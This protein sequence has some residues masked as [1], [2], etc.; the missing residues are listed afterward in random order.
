MWLAKHSNRNDRTASAKDRDERN[1][2]QGVAEQCR[3]DPHTHSHDNHDCGR[4]GSIK[5]VHGALRTRVLALGPRIKM[6][7]DAACRARNS[8]P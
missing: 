3:S 2:P 5:P 6:D 4:D 8:T 7:G 1:S